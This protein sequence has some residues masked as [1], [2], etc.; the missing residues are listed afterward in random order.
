[1]FQL[2]WMEEKSR[3]NISL[4]PVVVSLDWLISIG[5]NKQP[6][7]VTKS[8]YHLICRLFKFLKKL[9]YFLLNRPNLGLTGC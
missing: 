8:N 6:T 7:K 1:M 3:K 2:S 9:I 4:A 5:Y